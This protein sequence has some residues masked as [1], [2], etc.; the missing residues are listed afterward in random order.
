M[1]RHQVRCTWLEPPDVYKDLSMYPAIVPVCFAIAAIV[2]AF[3]VF[4]GGVALGRYIG[5]QAGGASAAIAF[6]K[7]L[8]VA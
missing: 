7:L 2:S 8:K 6:Y 1:C 3:S 4:K 5:A